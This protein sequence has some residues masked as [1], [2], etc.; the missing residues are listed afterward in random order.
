M[1]KPC[2]K[3]LALG[4]TVL[5]P[6]IAQTA[7]KPPGPNKSGLQIISKIPAWDSVVYGN[8]VITLDEDFLHI[9]ATSLTSGKRLWKR[10][11]QKKA[12]G[13]HRLYLA[14]KRLFIYAGNRL[15]TFNIRSGERVA[16]YDVPFQRGRDNPGGCYLDIQAASCAINCDCQFQ[17]CS[18]ADGA[19]LGPKYSLSYTCMEDDTLGPSS[20]CFGPQGQ[21]LGQA[22]E[23]WLATV[24]NPKSKERQGF[25]GPQMIVAVNPKS[26]Q[27]VYRSEKAG[28]SRWVRDLSGI[29][30]DGRICWLGN[31]D[32]ALKVF[33][34]QTGQLLWQQKGSGPRSIGDTL[35]TLV[36]WVE[37][38][39]GLYITRPGQAGLYAADS[40]KARWE[41][42]LDGKNYALPH[43]VSL[44]LVEER[45][46]DPAWKVGYSHIRGPLEFTLLDPAD[47][48]VQKHL[49]IENR[50]ILASDRQGGLFVIGSKLIS[51]SDK[52]EIIWQ[53]DW[54]GKNIV[55]AGA[56]FLVAT[57]DKELTVVDR[58]R[59]RVLG[60]FKGSFSVLEVKADRLVLFKHNQDGQGAAWLLK[61]G[62]T[63]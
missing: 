15:F 8:Q 33:A 63:N 18:C 12:V 39:P 61:P 32:G 44:A 25:A 62:Q 48:K 13:I 36:A 42:K 54:P 41:I 34:C 10:K 3:W 47:G 19:V 29:S 6:L 22:G 37:K 26:G 50:T 27:E 59:Q 20:G 38:P 53:M 28:L 51:Y 16:V 49:K 7:S 46:K 30:P 21:P 31:L 43:G 40:G 55:A 45:R 2:P 14:G 9:S 52:L 24:E 60:S 58:L 1:K 23:L 35:P 5:I 4:L 57:D 17:F 11:F 56:K